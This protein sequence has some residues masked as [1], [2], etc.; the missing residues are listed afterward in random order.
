ME[1]VVVRVVGKGEG[2][3][4]DVLALDG[5]AVGE[6]DSVGVGLEDA[7]S[8]ELGGECLGDELAACSTVDEDSALVSLYSGLEDEEV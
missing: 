6:S 2:K 1:G 4:L 3:P 7:G 8:L 5:V